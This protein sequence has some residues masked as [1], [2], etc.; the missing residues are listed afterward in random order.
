MDCLWQHREDEDDD[1][2][3]RRAVDVEDD[4]RSPVRG[5]RRRS[6]TVNRPPVEN[7]PSWR[8]E[9]GSRF[10]TAATRDRS[11]SVSDGHRH[12]APTPTA[13]RN[14]GES[15]PVARVNRRN[16]RE[17]ASDGNHTPAAPNRSRR[18]GQSEFLPR[19]NSSPPMRRLKQNGPPMVL[20]TF[21]GTGDLRLF[22][23]RFD[24]ISDY[25]SWTSQERAQRIKMALTS[26]AETVLF[27]LDPD[28]TDNEVIDELRRRFGSEQSEMFHRQQLRSLKQK[29]DESLADLYSRVIKLTAL[30]FPYEN[31]GC[32]TDAVCKDSFINAINDGHVKRRL[33]EKDPQNLQRAYE[34]AVRFTSIS[35]SL[36]PEYN[37]STRHIAAESNNDRLSDRVKGLE[38]QLQTLMSNVSR[39]VDHTIQR[40]REISS[41]SQTA[42]H[43]T[44]DAPKQPRNSTGRRCYY[45]NSSDHLFRQCSEKPPNKKQLRPEERVNHITLTPIASHKAVEVTVSKNHKSR[46]LKLMLDSGSN[47]S[48]LASDDLK[49]VDHELRPTHMVLYSA[50][51]E[52]LKTRGEAEIRFKINGNEYCDLFVICDDVSNSLLSLD[53][54]RNHECTLDFKND[55]L[56]LGTDKIK[57][58]TMDDSKT[59][60]RRI[61]AAQD[62]EIPANHIVN[63]PVRL[64]HTLIAGAEGECWLT[65]LVCINKDLIAARAVINGS[66]HNC[67]QIC[68][69]TQK[70]IKIGCNANLGLAFKLDCTEN[71]LL[72]VKEIE[73][74]KTSTIKTTK[75][76]AITTA[77]EDKYQS[78][79]A[80]AGAQASYQDNVNDEFS[81]TFA[82]KNKTNSKTRLAVLLE[83][84][85]VNSAVNDESQ[86]EDELRMSL[87]QKLMATIKVDMTPQERQEIEKILIRF[88][89]TFSLN[90]YDSGAF[91]DYQYDVTLCNPNTAPVC[92]KIRRFPVAISN[93]LDKK[94]EEMEK[95]G[96]L[97][98]GTSP[99]ASNVLPILKKGENGQPDRIKLAFD[100]R[101]INRLVHLERFPLPSV[102]KSI[103][104]LAGCSIITKVDFRNAFNS[105]RL[106]PASQ[107]IL[108]IRSEKAQYLCLRLPYGLNS[109]SSVYCERVAQ[110]LS[111]LQDESIFCYIDDVALGSKSMAHH[112][113]LIT[114]FFQCVEKCQVKLNCDKT[115]ICTNEFS[116]V[117]YR[118]KN[119]ELQ[120]TDD[121]RQA[122]L[123]LAYP[124]TIRQLRAA[125]GIFNYL[126]SH[127]EN[128]AIHL[129]AFYKMLRKPQK[130]IDDEQHRRLFQ[131][132]KLKLSSAPNL[133]IFRDD[134]K[135]VCQCDASLEA[136]SFAVL[137]EN[138]KGQRFPVGYYS[139]L[140][141][142][143]EKS[144]CIARLELLSLV[145]GLK[146]T[147]YFLQHK[148]IYVETDSSVLA[149]IFNAKTVAPQVARH[150]TFLGN[151]D[152]RISHI[153]S[154]ENKICDFFSRYPMEQQQQPPRNC[155]ADT[156][157]NKCVRFIN[158]DISVNHTLAN[159]HNCKRQFSAKSKNKNQHKDC[160]TW[161]T[162]KDV[163]RVSEQHDSWIQPG[164]Q[165][166]SS[167]LTS[168]NRQHTAPTDGVTEDCGPVLM[169]CD[170]ARPDVLTDDGDLVVAQVT[171]IGGSLDYTPNDNSNT[172]RNRTPVSARYTGGAESLDSRGEPGSQPILTAPDVDARTQVHRTVDCTAGTDLL[173]VNGLH[174]KQGDARMLVMSTAQTVGT[175]EVE[176]T[177]D[178]LGA[179]SELGSSE[180]DVKP[181]P[182]RS[183][184]QRRRHQT[185]RPV[186]NRVNRQSTETTALS[187]QRSTCIVPSRDNSG[188]LNVSDQTAGDT[189]QLTLKNI[190]EVPT[191]QNDSNVSSQLPSVESQQLQHTCVKTDKW[192]TDIFNKLKMWCTENKMNKNSVEDSS[193]NL[194][195]VNVITRQGRKKLEQKDNR[196]PSPEVIRPTCNFDFVWSKSN[197]AEAQKN[198]PILGKV[199]IHLSQNTQP[200]QDEIDNNREYLAY[201]NQW[202]SLRLFENVVYREFYN[203]F[204]NASRLQLLVPAI[205]RPEICRRVHV[206]ELCHCRVLKKHLLKSGENFYWPGQSTD[207]QNTISV[208]FECLQSGGHTVP[209]KAFISSRVFSSAPGIRASIDLVGPL[210]RSSSGHAYVLTILDNFSKKLWAYPIRSKSPKEVANKLS[211]CMSQYEVFSEIHSDLGKEFNCD[212]MKELC[213]QFGVKNTFNP[214]YQARC[215][216]VERAH[217]TISSL[218]TRVAEDHSQ[219][220]KI[221]IFAVSAYNRTVHSSTNFA[222][223][224]LYFGRPT[225]SLQSALMADTAEVQRNVTHGEFLAQTFENMKIG[226]DLVHQHLKKAA[227]LNDRRY[228]RFLK[229]PVDLIPGEVVLVFSPRRDPN[230]V[231]KFRRT[232]AQKAKVV[233]RVTPTLY[234]L[235]FLNRRKPCLVSVDKIR[236]IPK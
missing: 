235:L 34:L 216:A 224:H 212:L 128:L 171:T 112:I 43:R 116:L 27:G 16:S 187:N 87:V 84:S 223:D 147:Q 193:V 158:N 6:L 98:K 2:W 1:Q 17:Q 144:Y 120:M 173:H 225:G 138:E 57:L 94:L 102:Q 82:A 65:E 205:L 179:S 10:R 141:N 232:F 140:F 117:G 123:S 143:T 211:K 236:S 132:V 49:Y 86:N 221:L 201:L 226:Y 46:R 4:V 109:A 22:L 222:P 62:M 100:L 152:I 71:V 215:C 64:K 79:T 18:D 32:V 12:R 169:E 11:S 195:S 119:G 198:D 115:Q 166:D 96:L 75:V 63:L 67:L 13:P 56:S 70:S 55:T 227:Q 192:T 229:P 95:H 162:C 218:V 214:P 182:R 131:E 39:L 127:A 80:D 206:A 230:L 29:K 107:K 159:K 172:S 170:L 99:Y 37:R 185:A 178:N 91:P 199:I 177:T 217:K 180:Q 48:V 139:G 155:M 174:S 189:K 121:R 196:D 233:K 42:S 190:A 72:P 54:L 209:R 28:A 40:D 126:K 184:R 231:E 15:T 167:N 203:Q 137:H 183:R 59:C 154:S 151:F 21:D 118:V 7:R 186:D 150:L 114:R 73:S 197:I 200:T 228:N 125:L 44:S 113:S 69:P 202:N 89:H 105:V 33:L 111:S 175:G 106:A 36:Q 20:P 146:K 234:S 74:G 219:W 52:K 148:T 149:W 66:V 134:M 207:Y 78:T 194:A 45:C 160:G 90:E 8:D 60:V 61:K 176:G 165:T 168:K 81:R 157:C 14:P 110:M 136:W 25:Y 3:T 23:F 208:C 210:K 30:A 53:W 204:G 156:P 92:E 188:L 88:R 220:H 35:E 97:R 41:V 9:R 164:W 38:D 130:L 50:G 145:Y 135:I 133:H 161:Q 77:N 51:N 83:T 191:Q 68:N 124:R 104:K 108:S 31:R 122:L 85:H 47:I 26:N 103:L 5:Q 153:K 181:L 101:A 24:T 93:L 163:D 142:E 213:K 129:Q 58:V 19:A 76:C